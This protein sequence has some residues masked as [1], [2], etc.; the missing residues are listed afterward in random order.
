MKPVTFTS[1]PFRP[2]GHAWE[3]Q[4]VSLQDPYRVV[5]TY[6]K[7][8]DIGSYASYLILLPDYDL[9]FTIPAAGSA[10]TSI[11]YLIGS[12]I[13]GIIIASAEAAARQQAEDVYVGHTKLTRMTPSLTSL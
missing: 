3:I 7:A 6:T 1:D 2:V 8:G 10:L 9:G 4:R 12:L 5:D 11:A 13:G